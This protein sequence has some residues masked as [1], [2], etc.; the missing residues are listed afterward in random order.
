MQ[1]TCPVSVVI[2]FFN[3]KRTLVKAVHSVLAQ[4]L[5]P[6]ELI[7]LD[8]GSTDD[9]F[10]EIK[11]FIESYGEMPT[12]IHLERFEENRGVYPVR[13]QALDIASQSFV[14]FHDADDF[15]HL[16]KLKTQ[17]TYLAND[18]DLYLICNTV[19]CFGGKPDNRWSLPLK[20]IT[21]KRLSRH[22]VLWRNVIITN[23]VIIR[24][25]KAFRFSENKKRGSDTGLWL[26][27]I[28]SGHKGLCI[29]Q[30]LSFMRKPFFGAGGLSGNMRKAEI[31]HQRNLIEMRD[32]DLISERYRKV[33]SLWSYMKYMRRKFIVFC[34][35]S[36]KIML[37][38]AGYLFLT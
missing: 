18:D 26:S 33:L 31:A 23:S 9:G 17:Y 37:T 25:D 32:K 11:R 16:D 6:A 2:P 27:I 10:S 15:W 14:A 20:K 35:Q 38:L 34:R 13:N 28:L 19:V 3:S 1:D 30:P 4:S 29:Q 36:R 5:P 22:A 12:K 7:L 8:D 21:T 24:K